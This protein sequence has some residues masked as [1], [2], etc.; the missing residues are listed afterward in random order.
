MK[1]WEEERKKRQRGEEIKERG[2]EEERKKRQKRGEERR[3]EERR[4]EEKRGEMLCYVGGWESKRQARPDQTAS[5]SL[6]PPVWVYDCV[7]VC[8]FVCVCVCVCVWASVPS[9]QPD[10]RAGP[11]PDWGQ[12]VAAGGRRGG[13]GGEVGVV[14]IRHR[15]L[16][17]VSGWEGRGTK[18][19][20]AVWITTEERGAEREERRTRRRIWA[21]RGFFFWLPHTHFTTWLQAGRLNWVKI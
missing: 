1:A 4:G 6:W 12:L 14:G 18:N 17:C 20:T 5:I 2:E 11:A 7:C 13:R 3:G 16:T 10:N 15:C 9:P 8:V 19:Q 21:T